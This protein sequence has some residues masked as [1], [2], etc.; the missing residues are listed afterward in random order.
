M[1]I[2]DLTDGWVTDWSQ[3]GGWFK[4][5][6]RH[7]HLTSINHGWL[8]ALK[9]EPVR[10]YENVVAVIKWVPVLWGNYDWD[11]SYLWQIM[12]YKLRKM[13]ELHETSGN[14]ANAAQTAAQIKTAE[15]CLDRLIKDDYCAEEWEAYHK[16]YPERNWLPNTSN[17]PFLEMAPIS[18]EQ[19]QELS[20]ISSKEEAL[21]KKDLALFCKTFEEHVRSWW[22]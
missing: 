22:D 15:D 19:G 4:E 16:K 3:Q 11:H 6:I 14:S 7:M 10:F 13:R 20:D 1:D 21:R 5:W 12:H 18:A 8:Y 9:R 17:S 2:I